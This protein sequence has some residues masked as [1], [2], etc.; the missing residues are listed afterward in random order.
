[1]SKHMQ[2]YRYLHTIRNWSFTYVIGLGLLFGILQSLANPQA[3]M[4]FSTLFFLSS[5]KELPP[6]E[7]KKIP[8]GLTRLPSEKVRPSLV[9]DWE[10]APQSLFDSL[11]PGLLFSDISFADVNNDNFLDFF[12]SGKDSVDLPFTA[13][14]L[15]SGGAYR[16]D[17]LRSSVFPPISEAKSAWGDYD[18]DGDIDLALIGR[19]S[20]ELFAGIFRNEGGSF[21]VVTSPLIGVSGGDVDWVDI[22]ND[23]YLDL[24]LMGT[25]NSG[26]ITQILKNRSLSSP[27]DPFEDVSFILPGTWHKG[28][29]AWSDYNKDGRVDVAV[30]GENLSGEPTTQLFRNEGDGIWAEV[31]GTGITSLSNATGEWGDYNNDGY[32]DLL[33]S[34]F[35]DTNDPFLGVFRNNANDRFTRFTLGGVGGTQANWGDLDEDGDLDVWV[36][37]DSMGIKDVSLI[38]ANIGGSFSIEEENSSFLVDV[39]SGSIGH[40]DYDKDGLLDLFITGQDLGGESVFEVYHNL[41]S[42]PTPKPRTPSIPQNLSAEQKGDTLFFYWEAPGSA[43]Y[44]ANLVEG[45]TY[46]LYVGIGPNENALSGNSSLATGFRKVIRSGNVYHETRWSLIDLPSGLYNWGLQSVDADYEG[47]SFINGPTVEFV[48]PNWT[49]STQAYL[50]GNTSREEIVEPRLDQLRPG[51]RSR[52]IA[53]WVYFGSRR[54]SL[55]REFG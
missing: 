27:S 50:G 38:Y 17:S 44:P 2:I 8:E 9:P 32:P 28:A 18:N 5:E 21:A 26:P 14:Y 20:T 45:L 12:I 22:D 49:L 15:F 46:N 1:M 35:T 4:S 41:Y 11:P 19:G 53:N 48:N 47:S 51:P 16:L 31:E 55:I 33:I 40:V 25:G 30:V 39:T 37:G 54:N 10:T 23:G 24:S 34:G 7:E 13:I 36:L 3:P 6:P 29:M 42:T 43:Q 52:L